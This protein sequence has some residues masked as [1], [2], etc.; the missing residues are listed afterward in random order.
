MKFRRWTLIVL[1]ALVTPPGLPAYSVLAHEA[2]IDSAWDNSIK[3]LLLQRFPDSDRNALR[4]A[5]AYAYGGCIIQDMGYYPF[6]SKL[7]TDLAHYART[8]EFVENLL[9]ESQNL[10]EYAFALGAL[11]HYAA[12][13]QG[14]SVAVNA[15]VPIAYPKLRRKFGHAVTYEEDPLAHIRVEFGFDVLQVARGR[16]APE[17]YHDFIG[18]EVAAAVLERAFQDTYSL[19]LK[20]LFPDLD[21]ALGT[22]RRTVSRVIPEMTKVA[23]DLKKSDLQKLSPGITRSKFLYNLSAASYRKSWHERYEKPGVGARV[24]AFAIRILPKIGPLK[25]LSVKLP[26]AQ[27]EGLFEASFDKT[28]GEYRGLLQE[29]G[30][31]RLQLA[32]L[33]LDT[34][35]PVR[36][37]DYWMAD[38]AYAQLAI[39]LGAKDPSA[40][41][42]QVRQDVLAFFGGGARPSEVQTR[43]PKVWQ[44]AMAALGK[45]REVPAN[46]PPGVAQ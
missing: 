22:Y 8:G 37:G 38:N 6:G 5:H 4:E 18:F 32:D 17:S 10:D 46:G 28:L 41:D 27:T 24:L 42:P 33:D 15:S 20:D 23:W 43:D 9:R 1:A 40:V 12:D 16:Y 7:F 39:L 3:P 30:E 26:T 21:L 11:A 34:G 31:N 19:E 14:H 13:S 25:A 44:R 29:Q 36:L 45:L 2:I 35:A